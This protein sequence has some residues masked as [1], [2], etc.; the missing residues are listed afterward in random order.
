MINDQKITERSHHSSF[1]CIKSFITNIQILPYIEK[2]AS[3]EKRMQM[4]WLLIISKT[5]QN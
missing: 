1:A 3:K 4:E 2:I 5:A